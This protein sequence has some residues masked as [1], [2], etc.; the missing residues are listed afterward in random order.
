MAPL[1]ISALVGIG[2]KIATDLFMSGAKKVMR[3][4]SPGESGTSF[5]N[6]L[7]KARGGT[8]AG[9]GG[10]GPM[11]AS[12]NTVAL[13]AGLGDRSKVMAPSLSGGAAAPDTT[14]ALASY[15]RLNEAQAP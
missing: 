1:L 8:A 10:V 7:D 12:A 6:T 2:V 4:G 3:P 9:A 11:T 13:D 5:A 15:R 14:R